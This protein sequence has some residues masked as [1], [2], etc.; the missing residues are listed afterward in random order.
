LATKAVLRRRR[1]AGAALAEAVIMLPVFTIIFF[2]VVYVKNASVVALENL[3][4]AREC[5]WTYSNNACQTLPAG[6]EE[7]KRLNLNTPDTLFRTDKASS[8][9]SDPSDDDTAMKDKVTTLSQDATLPEGNSSGLAGALK[10]AVGTLLEGVAA[11]FENDKRD[12][13]VARDLNT[14]K[15]LGNRKVTVSSGYRMPCNVPAKTIGEVFM[16]FFDAVNPF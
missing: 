2:G 12:I 4:K 8:S 11:I 9:S 3:S 10:S 14:G 1:E 13:S 15:V 6:C 7:G 5:A 16:D